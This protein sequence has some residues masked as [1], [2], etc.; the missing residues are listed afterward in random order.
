MWRHAL[1]SD[2][3][4]VSTIETRAAI[5]A[6]GHIFPES[7]AQPAPADLIPEWTTYLAHPHT[8]ALISTEP[9]DAGCICIV[10][11][12][13]VPAGRRLAR[14]YV[15]PEHWGV[16]ISRTLYHEALKH[17][18]NIG[19]TALNLWVLEKNQRARTI[20]ESW[21]WTLITETSRTPHHPDVVEVMYELLV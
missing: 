13:S 2:A 10:A 3:E 17:E 16:G 1:V 18:R 8:L 15:Q 14:L 7:A 12:P 11:D 4:R 20:Y 9:V 21:G 5:A 19:T 6:F